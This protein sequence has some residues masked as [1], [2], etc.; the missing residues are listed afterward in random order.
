MF[1]YVLLFCCISITQ[2]VFPQS[3]DKQNL[4]D[5]TMLHPA[6]N[7]TAYNFK[8]GEWAYNQAL[9]P[10]P[11]WAWWGITDWLTAELDFEAWLGGVP[12]FNFRF[13][14]KEQNEILPSL[15]YET[16]YQYIKN[17]FDQFHNLDYLNID[18]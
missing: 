15:A 13:A 2:L 6:D 1:K 4:L 9:T 3:N 10:Y 18:H 14:L 12:S 16:M 17:E 7:F 11:S 5:E 8:K